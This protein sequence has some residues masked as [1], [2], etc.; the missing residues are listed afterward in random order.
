MNL[1]ILVTL[2][3][4]FLELANV[5]A[6]YFRPDS[7]NFN[8]LGVFNAWDKSKSDPEIHSLAK[9][10]A[11]WVAGT[12]LIVLS[13]LLVIIIFGDLFLQTIAVIVLI[14]SISSFYWRL[15]PLAKSMDKDDQLTPKNYSRTLGA[16][17]LVFI[18]AFIAALV[19]TY[20]PQIAV[21]LGL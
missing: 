5:L 9:Y 17:I 11:W 15:Y 10:L 3:F 19:V 20:W 16:M 12:K 1:L 4:I 7:K 18:L 6:L 2:F 14:V 21:F 13:L 8:S